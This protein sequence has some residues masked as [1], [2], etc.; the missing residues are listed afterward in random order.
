MMEKME[1][2]VCHRAAARKKPNESDGDIGL[3]LLSQLATVVLLA[4]QIHFR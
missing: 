4:R 2:N 3:G 1:M